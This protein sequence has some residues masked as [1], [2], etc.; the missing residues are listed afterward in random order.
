M[1]GLINRGFQNYVTQIFGAPLWGEICRDIDLAEGG[2]ET[3]LRYPTQLS[4]AMIDSLLHRVTH[5]RDV[6]LEDFGT[7]L[8]SQHAS[9]AV[10]E[11]LQLGA[12]DYQRFLWGLPD[13]R[14]RV[15]IALPD[16]ELPNFDLTPLGSGRYHLDF[17][18]R[19]AGYAPVFLGVLRAMAD[20]YQTLTTVELIPSD[21]GQHRRFLIASFGPILVAA[22]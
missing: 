5:T 1:H 10:R 16:F 3:M 6:L 14:D 13:L 7:F 22:Q 20:Y 8:I 17:Q 19:Y 21:S 18:F 12:P 15:Q 4:E 2:F 9:P 11:L